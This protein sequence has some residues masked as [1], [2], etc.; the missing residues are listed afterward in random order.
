M[1]AHE[2][3]HYSNSGTGL[4]SLLDTYVFLK[5]YCEPL[6]TEY[7]RTE[8]G[9]MGIAEFEKKNRELALCLFG[10]GTPDEEQQEMLAYV[11]SSGVY[12][13]IKHRVDNRVKALGGGR[14]GKR[15]YILQRLFLPMESVR[16]SYPFFYRHKLL[17]PGLVLYRL[18]IAALNWPRIR[19]ELHSMRK[20]S[21]QR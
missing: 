8:A 3:K 4:R 5:K 15:R 19:T 1:L 12:G 2:Y 18:G 11:V 16:A 14:E 9:K 13:S 21:E 17:L 20:E 7:I 6:N 10:G